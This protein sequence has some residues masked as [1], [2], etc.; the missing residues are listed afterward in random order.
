MLLST[1]WVNQKIKEEIKKY[2]ETNENENTTVPNL[3]DAVKAVLRGK[4]MAIQ[5]WLKKQ[6][7]SQI[8]NITLHVKELEQQTK[9]KTSRRKEIMKIRDEINDTQTKKQ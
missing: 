8:N 2:M 6:G 7:K 4:F 1:E 9:T 3:W 5:A